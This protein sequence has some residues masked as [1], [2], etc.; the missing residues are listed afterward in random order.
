MTT[1]AVRRR[2]PTS[3]RINCATCGAPFWITA[4]QSRRGKKY[5][6]EP[7]Q[8]NAYRTVNGGP[9]SACRRATAVCRGM[10]QA[11]YERTRYHEAPERRQQH[12]VCGKRYHEQH[13]DRMNALNA[14][15]A[16]RRLYSGNDLLA[17]ERDGYR[18]VDCGTSASEKRPRRLTVHHID[19]TGRLGPDANNDLANLISLCRRCHL[20]RHRRDR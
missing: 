9:C 5:C 2:A 13:R 4:S 14:Q 18:C 16:S 8:H 19:R 7:C 10:C 11:C 3:S 6:S 1:S 15:A 20:N 17:L 12:A